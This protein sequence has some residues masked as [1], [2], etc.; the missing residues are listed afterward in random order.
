MAKNSFG[1][2]VGA[3]GIFGSTTTVQCDSDSTSMYCRAVK[4]FNLLSM[5]A[6]IAFIIWFLMKKK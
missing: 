1:D 2:R 4:A 5:L 3:L 6:V